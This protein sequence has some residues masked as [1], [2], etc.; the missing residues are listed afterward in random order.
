MRDW[1]FWTDVVKEILSKR[2]DITFTVIAGNDAQKEIKVKFKNTVPNEIRMLSGISDDEL[3]DEYAKSE[4][5]F[6]PLKDSCANNALLEAASME[7]PIMVTDLPATREYLTDDLGI[8]FDNVSAK[9]TSARLQVV[10][11][12]EDSLKIKGKMLRARAE[13]EFSWDKIAER[14]LRL[15]DEL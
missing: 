7:V 11:K 1:G 10:L 4:I 6:L 9:A 3:R 15:Y 2:K 8:Y 13:K 14:Y 12:N 5:L